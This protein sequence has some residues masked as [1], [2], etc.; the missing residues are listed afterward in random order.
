MLKQLLQ[1]YRKNQLVNR[2]AKVFSVDVLVKAS[3]FILLPIYLK[4]M[5]Q[6]EYGLYNYMLSIIGV[7]ALVLNFGLYIPQIKL[8]QSLQNGARKR[9]AAI[10]HR[11]LLLVL[12]MI[13]LGIVYWFRLDFI[14]VKILFKTSIK[15]TA[16]R[17]P[18]LFGILTTITSFM[19][20][21]YFLASEKIPVVQ[22]YNL[23]RLLVG[24]GLVIVLLLYLTSKSSVLV[25][26]WGMVSVETLLVLCFL[27]VYLKN[28]VIH[29][30]MK[31]AIRSL[32]LASPILISGIL[33][34]FLSFNDKFILEKIASLSIL[35]IYYLA[36]S[37]SNILPMIFTTLQ[38]V[39]QPIFYKEHDL[40]ES[41]RKTKKLG[42]QVILIFWGF[43][44]LCLLQQ[45]SRFNSTL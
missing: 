17:V 5:T 21:N 41:L 26:L 4:L 25:R 38:N 31:I 39:W 9:H 23:L 15:Y 30:D 10:C 3:G 42:G 28:L 34:I 13:V 36:I 35:S 29:F 19:L 7:F 1:F 11:V 22:R 20:F 12:L 14:L 16:F 8:Y 18:V 33:N 27:P 24:N 40:H 45:S 32:G 43:P 2:F 6:E 44:V 37:I